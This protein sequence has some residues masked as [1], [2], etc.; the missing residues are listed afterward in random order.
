MKKINKLL[1]KLEMKEDN[2]IEIERK[3]ILLIKIK[4]IKKRLML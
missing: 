4:E 1:K 3:K 2:I